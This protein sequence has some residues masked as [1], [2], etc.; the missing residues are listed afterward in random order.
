[1][2]GRGD[3]LTILSLDKKSVGHAEESKQCE[4]GPVLDGAQWRQYELNQKS[5]LLE[6]NRYNEEEGKFVK[7]GIWPFGKLQAGATVVQNPVQ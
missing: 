2:N 5:K 7:K 4:A 6:V 3:G 1:V